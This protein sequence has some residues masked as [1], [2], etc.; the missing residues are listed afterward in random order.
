MNQIERRTHIDEENM[1]CGIDA[2]FAAVLSAIGYGAGG[3]RTSDTAPNEYD[4]NGAR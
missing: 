2:G 1:D 3:T 4:R